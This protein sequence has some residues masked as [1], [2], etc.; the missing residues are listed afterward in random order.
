MRLAL[1]ALLRLA[2]LSDR[3]AE[4]LSEHPDPRVRL[5]AAGLSARA[6]P[7]RAGLDE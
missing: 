3:A 4:E 5:A 1:A 2:R 6:H 7:L